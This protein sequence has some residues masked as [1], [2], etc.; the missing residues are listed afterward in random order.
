[1]SP[2][3]LTTDHLA[4]VASCTVVSHQSVNSMAILGEGLSKYVG[5]FKNF[6]VL[7]IQKKWMLETLSRRFRSI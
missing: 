3:L 4:S 1:M 5:I 7:S 6:N 2:A